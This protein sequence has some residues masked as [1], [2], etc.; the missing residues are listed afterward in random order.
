MKSFSLSTLLIVVL[1]LSVFTHIGGKESEK[2]PIIAGKK[3]AVAQTT[4]GKVRGYIHEGTHIYKGIPYAKAERFMPPEK[5]DPWEGIRSSMAW[6]PT[7][8]MMTPPTVRSDEVEFIFQHD[9]GYFGEDCQ[10]L[11]IWTPE[12]NDGNKRPVMV[13]I[14]GGGYAYGSSQELPSYDGE[15]LSKKGDIVFVSVNHRL[16]VLGFTDLSAFGEKYKSS[17]NVGIIDLVAALQWVKENIANF[18]GNPDNV[19]I[20]GQSG[21]GG[22]VGTLMNAPSAK[23][24]FHRAVIQSGAN[25]KFQKQEITR[26]IGKTIVAELG[27]E[28]S[29]VDSIQKV[30]YDDLAAAAQR[31]MKKVRE[32]LIAEGKP[33]K[34]Y[35][36]GLSP[37]LDGEFLP[38]EPT[39]PRALA[40][41]EDVPLM[42]GSTKNEFI[43]SL[44]GNP[45]LKDAPRDTIVKFIKKKYDDKADAYMAA[46]KKA[47]PN[48]TSPTDLI[49]VD[50]MFRRGT[51]IHANMKSANTNAPVFMYMFTW[52]SPVFDGA[53]KA[54]H[55]M[56][57]PFVFNNIA[58]CEEMTGGGESAYLLADKVSNVWIN[59]ARKGDPNHDGLPN[60]PAY[61]EENG[62]AMFFDNECTVRYH[63]DKELLKVTED[64][65][66]LW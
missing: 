48:D 39:D 65:S 45:P 55:C 14:H 38:Y 22:K 56:E 3:I 35:G 37:T 57:L 34:G 31:A 66:S 41:S 29:Q 16:N 53:Y 52:Q 42:I 47:F 19:T 63:H 27:L 8:P 51:V 46:V 4:S 62:A 23:G 28:P 11:N 25:P 2:T 1:C 6:G 30:P 18:G 21:G 54:I 15:S 61:S 43:A 20:F 32:Q 60:W 9:W 17:V 10:R 58:L 33:P 26:R 59:F 13:W 12:I 36:Y 50:I 7:C 44:W 5:P 64:G 40:L 24:L 49:D